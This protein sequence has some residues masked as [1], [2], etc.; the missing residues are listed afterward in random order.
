MSYYHY[1]YS[2]TNVLLLADVFEKFINTCLEYYA[3]EPCHYFSSPE[4]SWDAMLK[5][6]G[7][8]L[9]LISNIDTDLFIE[10]TMRGGISYIA[11]RHTEAN[12]KYMKRYDGSKVSK[13]IM[14]LDANNLD[15][16]TINIYYKVDLNG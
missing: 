3:L 16:W 6:T 8:E 5:M 14:Y 10:K 11:K 4:L 13:F 2:K 9:K 15:S 7:I 1:L 12:N